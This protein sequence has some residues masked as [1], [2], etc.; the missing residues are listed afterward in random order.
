M[1]D[2]AFI[3]QY[4]S[5]AI[6]GFEQGKSLL[7]SSVTTEAVIKG[8]QAEFLVADSGGSTPVTRGVNGLIPA[9]TDNLNQYTATLTEWHDLARRTRFNIFASQGDG[10]RIMQETTRKVMNRKIDLDILTELQ[11]ATNTLGSATTASLA[12]V[13]KALTVLTN[14]EVDVDEEDNMFFVISGAFRAYLMQIPEFSKGSYVEVKP[15]VGPTKTYYRWGGF[16]W[17][18]HPNIVGKATSTEYCFAYHRSAIGHAVNTGEMDIK[19]GYHEEQDYSWARST[20]FMGSKVLQNKG[21]V[22]VRHDG[23][24]YVA[25]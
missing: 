21:I 16:N 10:R 1:A 25:S 20:M 22:L 9:R 6:M 18:V 4:R 3:I 17:I 14:N 15:L 11:N 24:A 5:E 13:Q 2:T 8:N 12:L 23:S 19:A 7:G